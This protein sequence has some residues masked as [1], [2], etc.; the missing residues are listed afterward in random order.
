GAGRGEPDGSGEARAAAGAAGRDLRAARPHEARPAPA[1]PQG[2]SLG[3]VPG[4]HVPAALISKGGPHTAAPLD[5]A[6]LPRARCAV[7]PG[8]ATPSR[9]GVVIEQGGAAPHPLGPPL[10]RASESRS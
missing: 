10:A 3:A 8:A 1:L 4:S 9:S 5:A 7:L 6:G 2:R